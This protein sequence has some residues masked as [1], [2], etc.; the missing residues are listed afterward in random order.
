[1]ADEVCQAWDKIAKF[2]PE[3]GFATS[4][5]SRYVLV[6]LTGVLACGASI[7]NGKF[8]GEFGKDIAKALNWNP[9]ETELFSTICYTAS[10]LANVPI[11]AR[12]ALASIDKIRDDIWDRLD[13]QCCGLF[14]PKHRLKL[15]TDGMLRLVIGG[16]GLVSLIG[17]VPNGIFATSD[18]EASDPAAWGMFCLQLMTIGAQNLRGLTGVYDF[19][20]QR[21]SSV[22]IHKTRLFNK[23]IDCMEPGPGVLQLRDDVKYLAKEQLTAP[24]NCVTSAFRKA[25]GGVYA[26]SVLMYSSA[27]GKSVF[28]KLFDKFLKTSS[29]PRGNIAT[30]M[31]IVFG[32]GAF[33]SIGLKWLLLGN[34]AY[35]IV[36]KAFALFERDILEVPGI[37]TDNYSI[38]NK[39][40]RRFWK[41]LHIGSSFVVGTLSLG[42]PSMIV[43][44][45][46]FK[47]A[48][49]LKSLLS[50][51]AIGGSAAWP[52]NTLDFYNV[53]GNISGEILA[54][55]KSIFPKTFNYKPSDRFGNTPTEMYLKF[56]RIIATMSVSTFARVFLMPFNSNFDDFDIE[57][58][59]VT[60]EQF[61]EM[62][63]LVAEMI[64]KG[65]DGVGYARNDDLYLLYDALDVLKDSK[66]Q[67]FFPAWKSGKLKADIERLRSHQQDQVTPI[68]R[69][70][71]RI[72]S[73]DSFFQLRPPLVS[74]AEEE[75]AP[76]ETTGLLKHYKK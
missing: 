66:A 21:E 48:Q 30:F 2:M 34:S 24:A 16:M 32:M 53:T 8:G 39:H 45:Y 29:D 41:G 10:L 22:S 31:E 43:L 51:L 47:N 9:E 59:H 55:L 1:A 62:K 50:S 23:T 36:G 3:A 27:F 71:R 44:R 33:T 4:Q 70:A 25:T 19:D 6:A 38:Q 54:T 26:G 11:N 64:E 76:T 67:R 56:I 17:A 75:D 52:L 46:L 42:S 18:Y 63:T 65:M 13:V 35:T 74:S 72:E 5:G 58:Q 12:S 15:P 60:R 40:L 7:F 49:D 20:K 73:Q 69:V 68:Q 57:A 28:D 37:N 14:R 61:D